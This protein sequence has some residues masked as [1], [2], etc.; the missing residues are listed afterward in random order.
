MPSEQQFAAWCGWF[1][2][3][4]DVAPPAGG[5]GAGFAGEAHLWSVGRAAIGRVQA[6]R[7]HAKR[8]TRNL[9]RDPVDH[10]NITVGQVETK[11]TRAGNAVIVPA[12]TPFVVSLGEPVE[13]EREADTRL[14]LYLPR[15]QFAALAPVLDRARHMPLGGATGRLLA[16]YLRLLE[17]SLPDLS[18]EDLARLANPIEAMIAACL[19]PCASAMR[20]AAAQVEFTR[21]EQIRKAIRRRLHSATLNAA[22]LCRDVG[23]SRSQLYRLLEGAGGVAHYIQHL[24]LL[25]AYGALSDVEDKRSI[26]AIAEAFGFY[27]ASTFSR[28]FRRHFG[29]TPS[30]LRVEARSGGAPTPVHRPVMAADALTLTSYLRRI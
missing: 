28:A 29:I 24:R 12:G 22:S 17:R 19:A 13:S 8:G 25:A 1:E 2:P 18:A 5:L 9:R 10:W 20:Q 7:L 30:D 4:F 27:D 6:P 21:M 14:Q 26:A 23:M 3:L 11:L 15:D 16:D